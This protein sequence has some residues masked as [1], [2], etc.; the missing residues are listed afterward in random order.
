L[1]KEKVLHLVAATV[2]GL[3]L[4]KLLNFYSAKEQTKKLV[5]TSMLSIA[6]QE[7]GRGR[8]AT[9]SRSSSNFFFAG[10]LLE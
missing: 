3:S 8:E 10:R 9:I 4:Y 6:S 5:C 1:D 2:D 7:H